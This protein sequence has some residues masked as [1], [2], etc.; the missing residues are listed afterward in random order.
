MAGN[1]GYGGILVLAVLIGCI[2]GAIA[3]SKGHSFV[4]WWIFG[5]AL[6]IVALPMSLMLKPVGETGTTLQVGATP[7]GSIPTRECPFCKSRI[8]AD[9]LVCPHCQR[10]SE[11][12]RLVRT[13]WV[14]RGTDGTFW[15]LQQ[16]PGTWFKVRQG[17][18]CPNCGS[19]MA[20][21]ADVCGACN[22]RSS[23]RVDPAELGASPP[24][25]S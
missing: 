10:E 19:I 14:G 8:R 12:W 13:V 4:L 5:A 11:P 3:Q 24:P 2:P 25:P 15:W 21:N 20:D 23:P 6:F 18:T 17:T 22:T 9:A 1:A 7:S 16:P